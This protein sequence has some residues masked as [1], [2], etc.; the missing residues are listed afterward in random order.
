MDDILVCIFHSSEDEKFP[1]GHS[2]SRI[3]KNGLPPVM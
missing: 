2:I 3:E 1:S